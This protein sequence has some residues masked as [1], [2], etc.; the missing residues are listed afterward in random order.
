MGRSAPPA[1]DVDE[2]EDTEMVRN[3]SYVYVRKAQYS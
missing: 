1:L 3:R 2:I